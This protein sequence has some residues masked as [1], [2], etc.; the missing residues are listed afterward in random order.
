MH[1]GRGTD[2]SW[3]RIDRVVSAGGRRARSC[4][5]GMV[6]ADEIEAV[7][8]PLGAP[9]PEAAGPHAS[10]GMHRK[11]YSPATKVLVTDALPSA[12]VAYVWWTTAA[13]EREFDSDAC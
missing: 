4:V 7:I 9:E 1:S 12:R 13:G 3:H 10:P 5:P 6:T 8:G 2:A 11:H